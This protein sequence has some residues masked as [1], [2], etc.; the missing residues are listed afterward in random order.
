MSVDS[1]PPPPS[2]VRRSLVTSLVVG[3]FVSLGHHLA[4]GAAW[5]P[6]VHFLLPV[7]VFSLSAWKA[8][9]RTLTSRLALRG[10]VTV[11]VVG[12]SFTA[13]NTVWTLGPSIRVVLNYVV[14]FVVSMI[15]G[16]RK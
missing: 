1:P 4:P 12:I 2:P 14:P 9:N 11:A 15:G 8:G 3:S 7:I 10:I 6:V 16:A 5:W 13:I